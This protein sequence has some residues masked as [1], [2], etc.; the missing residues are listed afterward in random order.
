MDETPEL[1]KWF[2]RGQAVGSKPIFDGICTMCGTLLCGPIDIICAL[3]SKNAGPP[4]SR[5]GAA[6]LNADGSVNA[7]A[8]PPFLLRFSPGLFTRETGEMFAH[9][10]DTNRRSLKPGVSEP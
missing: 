7:A 5:D 9:D 1:A 3:S 8:Q 10:A 4:I 6:V 2:M